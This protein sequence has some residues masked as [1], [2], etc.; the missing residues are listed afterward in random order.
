V[1]A[2]RDL[3]VGTAECVSTRRLGQTAYVNLDHAAS[4]PPLVAALD[5]LNEAARWY[6]NVH[7]GAGYKARR[8]T[9]RFEAARDRLRA[10]VGAHESAQT[11]VFVRNTTAALN[12][13]ARR[14]SIP[15][16]HVVVVTDMEHHS[17][18]LPWRFVAPVERV[19]VDAQG[20]V[21]EDEL[22]D[23]LRRHQGRVAVLAASAASNVTGWVNPVHR[24][25]AWA[26]AAGARIVVDAAQLAPH[27]RLD[28]HPADDPEHLDVVAFSGHKIYAPFG[29]GALVAP[30]D[31]LAS[32]DPVEVGGG[33][34][35]SVT[36]DHVVWTALPDREEAGTPVILGAIALAAA[37]AAIED[38]GWQSV[39]THED[40]LTARAI[41]GL[42]EI[43]G[44]TLYGGSEAGA[45]RLGVI[46]FNVAGVPH[47]KTA[48]IL[49]DEWGIGTRS[50]CFCAHPYVQALLGMDAAGVRSLAARVTAGEKRG[51]PGMVRASIGLASSAQDIDRLLEAVQAIARHD[52][53]DRYVEDEKGNWA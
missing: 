7:R 41:A 33:T 6:A 19:R 2:L 21:D 24:W 40:A 9:E 10:F 44:V 38:L 35:D 25:A 16:G 20:R 1:T 13:I 28:V 37:I 3:V 47:G 26:H 45:D 43:D 36:R 52:Y 12:H 29:A 49:G 5:A 22:R 46:P 27:R 11:L 18:D 48:A 34:V 8:T 53:D 39:T 50:G 31:V 14:L 4:T 51:L 17:N 42:Q 32:G 30:R 23:V 15:A